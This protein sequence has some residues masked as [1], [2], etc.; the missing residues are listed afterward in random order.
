MVHYYQ[1]PSSKVFTLERFSYGVSVHSL[2][3]THDVCL[4][5]F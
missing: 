3:R 2:S 1:H 4:I 5:S